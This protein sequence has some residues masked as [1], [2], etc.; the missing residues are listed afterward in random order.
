[1]RG[2]G[3]FGRLHQ[4][5]MMTRVDWLICSNPDEI[6]YSEDIAVSP[7][8]QRLFVAACCRRLLRLGFPIEREVRI[9]ERFAQG[10][11]STEEGAQVAACGQVKHE[12]GLDTNAGA[13]NYYVCAALEAAAA[14]TIANPY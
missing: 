1:M 7:R 8:K 6:L 9:L 12:E 11:A 4:G 3:D 13:V 14:P 2:K 10:K 5:A